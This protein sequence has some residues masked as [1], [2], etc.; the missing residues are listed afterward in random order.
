MPCAASSLADY[1]SL[2][3][4]RTDQDT[5]DAVTVE[6]SATEARRV[7][8][9]AQGFA[10]KRPAKPSAAHIR[11]VARRLH[12]LQIDTVNVLVR[13]HYLPLFSRLGPY[14]IRVLD[15]MINVSH[16]LVEVNGHAASFVPVELE[17]ALRS[18]GPTGAAFGHGFRDGIEAS[19]PGY[20]D[21]IRRAVAAR[22]PLS[23]ADLD[24]PGRGPR[25][26]PEEHPARRKDGQPYAASSLAWAS[27]ESAGK[28][29]LLWLVREG[30]VALA[31]RGPGF[32]RLFDLRERV[33]P[34][35]A[36]MSEEDS[37][38]ELLRRAGTA[39]G[40][41]T[42]KELAEYFGFGVTAVKAA[43]ASLV[44]EGALLPT[45]VEG[46]KSAAYLSKGARSPK[47]ID[48]QALVGPFDSLTWSRDRTKR[49]FGFDYSFEIYVPEPKRRYGYYVLPFLLGESLV[50]RVDLNADRQAGQLAVPGAFAEDGCNS[51]EVA[52]ELAAELRSMATW[53]GLGSVV[54][55]TRGD[56][57]GALKAELD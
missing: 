23:A 18:R 38:R 6:L 26:T 46:W 57:A 24:D 25:R 37:Q 15:E 7:A 45:R 33:L 16:E 53:L 40:V 3:R 31:G 10:Q 44:D 51:H 49:L 17:P 13:A 1:G 22:G 32:Q 29:V 8:L 36:Q 19:R 54:V 47:A 14:P 30:T 56:L 50:A 39:L 48:A 55:G 42:A 2:W 28:G 34:E 41:A 12:A 4:D 9:A 21:S 52:R 27:G 35:V 20:V 11:A 43:L 5:V